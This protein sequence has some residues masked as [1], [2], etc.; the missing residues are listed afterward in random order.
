MLLLSSRPFPKQPLKTCFAVDTAAS[1]A[2]RRARKARSA[3][4]AVT[5]IELWPLDAHLARHQQDHKRFPEASTIAVL[6]ADI[7]KF[8][9]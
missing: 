5:N 7:P 8:F 6:Q 3:F 9:N 2:I 1:Q 4:H